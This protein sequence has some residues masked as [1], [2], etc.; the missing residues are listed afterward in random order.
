MGLQSW[1]IKSWPIIDWF[2]PPA[3][4]QWPGFLHMST[5][6][7]AER[8]GAQPVAGNSVW[9][10]NVGSAHVGLAWEWVELRPGVLLLADP[11][12]VITNVRFV[13]KRGRALDPLKALVCVNRIMHQLPWQV[14]ACEVLASAG[15]LRAQ[16]LQPAELMKLGSISYGGVAA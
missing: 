15:D 4:E 3:S 1:M 13:D 12:S 5:R 6:V 14:A 2:L 8:R 10:G 16:Q 11:N 9:V 7:T